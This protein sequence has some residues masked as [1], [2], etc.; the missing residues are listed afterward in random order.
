M[1]ESLCKMSA[2]RGEKHGS[3]MGAGDRRELNVRCLCNNE[4]LNSTILR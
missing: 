3:A 1:A 4:V 2:Q